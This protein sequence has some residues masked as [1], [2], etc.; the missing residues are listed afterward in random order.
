M[1]A[2]AASRARVPDST[3]WASSWSIRAISVY[4]PVEIVIS[5]RIH[6][7]MTSATPR[8]RARTRRGTRRGKWL[9]TPALIRGSAGG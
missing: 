8:W 2:S 3:V 9:A 5:S 7:T 6:S 4:A 1:P